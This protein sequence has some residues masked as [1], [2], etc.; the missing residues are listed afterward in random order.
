MTSNR[1]EAFRVLGVP[2]GSDQRTVSRAYRRLARETHPDLSGD[3]AAADRFAALATAFAVASEP[4]PGPATTA[5]T[6]RPRQ[7]PTAAQRPQRRPASDG[8]PS[9]LWERPLIVA[10]PVVVLRSYSI[11]RGRRG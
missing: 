7:D 11:E 10:G 8:Q 2:T 6:P 1:T 3:P 5:P 4:V 9:D